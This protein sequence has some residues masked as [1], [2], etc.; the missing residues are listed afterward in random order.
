[1]CVSPMDVCPFN[2]VPVT[3]QKFGISHHILFWVTI[4]HEDKLK[5]Y[6]SPVGVENKNLAEVLS[7]LYTITF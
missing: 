3:T 5:V 1:M 7:H 2:P 6:I 4:G